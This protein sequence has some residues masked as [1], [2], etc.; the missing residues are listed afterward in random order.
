VVAVLAVAITGSLATA[1]H[2]TPST[3]D[4]NKKIDEASN[5]LEDVTESYNKMKISLD[6]TLAEEKKLA[7]SLGPAKAA[8]DEATAQVGT[9]AA[10][11][12]MQGNVG[13]MN[14]LLDGQD[15]MMDRMSYLDQL[16]RARQRD[17]ANYLSATQ[18]YTDRQ[19]AL[20]AT[21]DKQTAQVKAL[22]DRKKKI[23]ADLDKLYAM[24]RAAYGTATTSG[25]SH[26]VSPPAISGAAGKAVS[27]AFAA[28]NRGA[29]YEPLGDGPDTY[30]CSGLTMAA[31]AAAGK[32][33][34]H[35]AAAQYSA[36]ARISRSQLQPGDLIFYRSN[37]HVALYVGSGKIIDASKPGTPVNYRTMDIMV[38]NGYGRVR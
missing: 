2:A 35:N 14:V 25:G 23:K 22:A 13:L 33:L 26:N 29:M 6:Q 17:I 28:Y 34:P 30:D 8:L 21:Q 18:D 10:S 20:K 38:P 19:A 15:G 32:S 36:T 4:I 37:G 31:W 27:Y 11:A 3:S 16:S 9:I 12:Y 5:K 7:A 24:R 1:A